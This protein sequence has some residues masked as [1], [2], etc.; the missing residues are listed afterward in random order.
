MNATRWS[1]IQRDAAVF[2]G[3]LAAFMAGVWL[4]VSYGV[5]FGPGGGIAAWAVALIVIVGLVFAGTVMW[6]YYVAPDERNP[7]RGEFT[8]DKGAGERVGHVRGGVGSFRDKTAGTGVVEEPEYR[9]TTEPGF[10]PR[11]NGRW[12]AWFV[13]MAAALGASAA[14]VNF[15]KTTEDPLSPLLVAVGLLGAAVMLGALGVGEMSHSGAWARRPP[16]RG[17]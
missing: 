17:A 4:A 2:L 12:A 5:T 3:G 14:L 6:W 11:T 1:P 16:S 10:V 15:A 13:L 7:A 9:M 8:L